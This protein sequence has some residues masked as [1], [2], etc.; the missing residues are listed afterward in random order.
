[1]DPHDPDSRLSKIDTVWTMLQRAHQQHDSAAELARNELLLRY[2]G[3]VYR[4]L[5]AMVH[6]AAV[7]EELAQEFAVRFL[8][9]DFSQA[10]AQRG[11]FRDFL[12][13]A[14]RHLALD[15]WQRQKKE[16]DKGP[17]PLEED[18]AAAGPAAAEPPDSDQA[19]LTA[20][21]EAL[22]ASTWKALAQF[23]EATGH[24]YHTVLRVKV[25]P[26]ELHS[27]QVA[28]ELGVRLGKTFTELSVRQTLHRARKRFAELLVAEVAAS[29]P[30]TDPERLELELIELG[31]LDFCRPA[32]RRPGRRAGSS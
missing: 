3:A 18:P 29:L 5:R 20:W 10:D 2:Y 28:Q 8:R 27:A 19:F 17:R 32:L 25:G 13:T 1:M 14:V 21:R 31:L 23:E 22:L 11:R 7:A 9:G 12:K 16:K 15:Y 6:D 24:P 30:T 4:Y 26:P